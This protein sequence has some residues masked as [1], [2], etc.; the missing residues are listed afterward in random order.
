[1]ML[2]TLEYT[3]D[4]CVVGGGLAGMCAAIAAA[5]EGLKVVLMQE[6]P[7]VGGNASG[8]IRMWVCG[9][10]GS[11]V[12]E[13]GIMEEIALENL[14][15]NPYKLYPVW[16]ALLWDFV[17]RE[18]NITLLLNCSCMDAEM[19]DEHT[20]RAVVGWQMSTQ[21]FCRV[22]AD[23]FSDCSG[24]SILA[25]LTGAEFR[26]GREAAS[27]FGENVATLTED[28]KTMGNSCLIQAHKGTVPVVFHAPAFAKKLTEED[29]R[30]RRPHMDSSYENFWYLELGGDRD[31][32][33]DAETVRDE[34]VAL[35]YG[36]WDYVK[37][38]GKY[39]DAEY[40]QLDFLGFLAGK[41]ESRRMMGKYLM[42][43]NDITSDRA[44]D[45]V[46]AYG[47]WPL[48]D[49]DPAGFRYDGHPNTSYKTPAPYAIPYR[50][51][52][53]R[54]IENLYFAGRNISMTHAAMSSARVM[55]TCALLGQAVGTAAAVAKKYG[56]SPD[57]VYTDHLAEYQELLLWNDC[58]L[59]HHPR[60]PAALT[61]DA[62]L[63]CTDN[64]CSDLNALR[65][66]N[67]RENVFECSPGSTV[68][69]RFS[70]P[71]EPKEVRL[72]F[73]S[74]LDRKT[75]PGDACERQHA[76]RSNLLPNAPVMHLPTTLCR[77]YR[78]TADTAEG[79]VVLA[80]VTDNCHRLVKI[81]VG[82]RVSALHLT[83]REA[84]EG[85][86]TMR[87]FSFEAN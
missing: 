3:A 34:L 25:P 44:F 78:L 79:T 45:D 1:M 40:W 56:C 37:N 7:V 42:T 67:D 6:R 46:C 21:C 53:S 38:S 41:R 68:S 61:K 51:L 43:Q 87:L 63:T 4:L 62:E 14:R 59:P 71:A 54:N 29:L 2:K 64:R 13:T 18:T 15:L 76:M 72:V 27:E 55:A 81:P 10:Q 17:K 12:R 23:Y 85:G 31:T 82:I 26:I 47:G 5:R 8:E 9:A 32:I 20:I 77:S 74:D 48:D 58:L 86:E 49:H 50:V 83:L 70:V 60:M 66:G 30:F 57:G 73:D 33:G 36:I 39:P 28:K 84:N 11:N 19:A 80:D 35:A 22:T 65:D 75:L 52:Y 16:D 24:D 69:Y